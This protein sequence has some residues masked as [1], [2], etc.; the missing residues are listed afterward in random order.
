MFSFDS[1]KILLYLKDKSLQLYS[2]KLPEGVVKWDFSPQVESLEIKDGVSFQKQLLAWIGPTKLGKEKAK[3]VIILS[4]EIVFSKVLPQ[5]TKD[6]SSQ[7]EVFINEIPIEPDKVAKIYFPTEKGLML[8]ATNRETYQT[9]ASALEKLGWQ[10]PA[11]VPSLI[12]GDLGTTLDSDKIKQIF[13]Q[14]NL[15]KDYNFLDP[16]DFTSLLAKS[17]PEEGQ[18]AE[19]I[20]KAGDNNPP[21]VK[22]RSSS[23]IIWWITLGVALVLIFVLAVTLREEFVKPPAKKAAV[24]VEVFSPTPTVSPAPV[25]EISKEELKVEILNGTGIAGQAAEVKKIMEGVGFVTIEMGNAQE[26]V[27]EAIV[28][29]SKNV[30][31]DIQAEVLEKLEKTFTK[32]WTRTKEMEVD[33]QITTGKY[34]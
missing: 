23:K 7:V 28:I 8:A 6:L 9:V 29:F 32:V 13:E 27:T 31:E 22:K 1:S 20:T 4:E 5:D 12:W 24:L 25:V 18:E 17:E 2:D 16:P 15:L 10:I 3:A 19:K 33:I 34:R 11:V 21:E 14:S 26:K 30:S